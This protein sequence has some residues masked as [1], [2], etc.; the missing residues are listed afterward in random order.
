MGIIV[1]LSEPIAD[2]L[3]KNEYQLSWMIIAFNKFAN[4]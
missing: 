2:W 4:D 1:D 3:I